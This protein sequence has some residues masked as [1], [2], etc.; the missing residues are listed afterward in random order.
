MAKS[1]KPKPSF[2]Q[3]GSP[4]APAS[5]EWVYRTDTVT[6]P[7]TATVDVVVVPA[8][9]RQPRAMSGLERGVDLISRPF[10]LVIVMGLAVLNLA[11]RPRTLLLIAVVGAT[12]TMAACRARE[13]WVGTEFNEDTGELE[14]ASEEPLCGCLTLANITG[15]DLT[16]RSSFQSSTTGRTT[17]KPGQ[18]IEFRYDW[19]GH[20]DEDVYILTG[21]TADGT[22]VPMQDAVKIVERGNFQACEVLR[23]EYGELL[24]NLGV[25]AIN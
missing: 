20:N 6:A 15:K 13:I 25:T 18:Q 9:P 12:L 19:A 7:A 11:R 1:R 10:G 3:P 24:L 14:V 16:I 21:T 17:L 23:C 5:A 8:G 4:A 2:D 22:P